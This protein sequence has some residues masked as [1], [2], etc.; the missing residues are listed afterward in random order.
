[1][2]AERLCNLLLTEETVIDEKM[3]KY[4]NE[5]DPRM[6]ALINHSFFATENKLTNYLKIALESNAKGTES[7]R[8]KVINFISTYVETHHTFLVEH[9]KNLFS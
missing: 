9:V 5:D 7:I 1:M 3:T 2:V 8:K 4:M 6:I